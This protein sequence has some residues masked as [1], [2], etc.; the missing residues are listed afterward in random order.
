MGTIRSARRSVRRP[1]PAYPTDRE[2]STTFCWRN[3][4]RLRTKPVIATVIL[5]LAVSIAMNLQMEAQDAHFH[6]ATASS[7]QE[8]NPYTGERAAIVEGATL[9]TR[10]CGACHGIGGRGTGNIP[11]LSHGAVQSVPDGELFWFI[12]T[13]SVANGMPSWVQLRE[14]QRWQLVTYV[15]SLKSSAVRKT[16]SLPSGYK[17]VPTN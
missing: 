7:A 2:D 3:C 17:P 1:A 16:I 4:M 5:F 15:T 10:N 6:N 11:A 9:Y 13:G 12:T 14:Q 8:K